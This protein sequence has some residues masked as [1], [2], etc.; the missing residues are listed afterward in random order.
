MITHEALKIY[1]EIS[2]GIFLIM[3]FYQVNKGMKNDAKISK[4]LNT[5]WETL[6]YYRGLCDGT[7]H[8]AGMSLS[9]VK[10][11]RER[12]EREYPNINIETK[13]KYP[14]HMFFLFFNMFISGCILLTDQDGTILKQINNL[15]PQLLGLWAVTPIAWFFL[16]VIYLIERKSGKVGKGLLKL[17]LL[18]LIPVVNVEMMIG[19]ICL[20]LCCFTDRETEEM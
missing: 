13:E 17:G 12:L 11:E 19:S 4:K 7:A 18:A 15:D 14:W 2:T 16:L 20:L 9:G 1:V 6:H 5:D 8:D 10:R 3:L